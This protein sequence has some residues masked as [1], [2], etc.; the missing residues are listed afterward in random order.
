M[1]C[2]FP[3]EPESIKAICAHSAS[4][5]ALDAPYPFIDLR[6][7][8]NPFAIVFCFTCGWVLL[9]QQGVLRFPFYTYR[10]HCPCYFIPLIINTIL[11]IV[12]AVVSS[13]TASPPHHSKRQP[14]FTT[15]DQWD[16]QR[17]TPS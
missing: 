4:D 9:V 10:R 12:P 15:L 3:E 1:L 8:R 16:R 7:R 14:T 13:W 2:S 11:Y 5:F 6:E 17:V